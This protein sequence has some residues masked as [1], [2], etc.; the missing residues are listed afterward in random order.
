MFRTSNADFLHELALATTIKRFE[1][2]EVI[3]KKDEIGTSMYYILEGAVDVASD[4]L[5]LIYAKMGPDEYF[6][7]LCLFY[8]IPRTAMIITTQRTIVL[9]LRKSAIAILLARDSELKKS[10]ESIALVNYNRYLNRALQNS[11]SK[12]LLSIS[13]SQSILSNL[14][15]LLE[16]EIV[17]L[18]S[19]FDAE[20][21]SCN[22]FEKGNQVPLT[23]ESFY[24]LVSGELQL[25]SIMNNYAFPVTTAGSFFKLPEASTSTFLATINSPKAEIIT[26]VNVSQITGK[27]KVLAMAECKELNEL[28][29]QQTP[30]R[31]VYISEGLT[32]KM[33][34]SSLKHE[35]DSK[36]MVAKQITPKY[37]AFYDDQQHSNL[38]LRP[39]DT[40]FHVKIVNHK[41]NYR[42]VRC[43]PYPIVTENTSFSHR[44]VQDMEPNE[45]SL[46]FSR[47]NPSELVKM[48]RTCSKMFILLMHPFMWRSLNMR[49]DFRRFEANIST[50]VAFM[51][52]IAL[53]ILDLSNCYAV[54]DTDL[55]IFCMR[56]TGIT[57][58]C[59]SSC[60]KVTDL[61]ISAFQNL[62]LKHLAVPHCSAITGAT[63]GS[64]KKLTSI[65]LSY[66]HRIT[67]VAIET[68]VKKSIG[69]REAIFRR[70]IR[71]SDFSVYLL[72]KFCR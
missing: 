45:L 64:W 26:F 65:D 7:E 41:M 35:T 2:G 8:E 13:V 61:G 49:N 40:H 24:L 60:I 30:T 21:I 55:R 31:K 36:F 37:P 47:L 43:D 23:E 54:T 22:A 6:G 27:A 58:I 9:E 59:L 16:I 50:K 69:I 42:Y 57:S 52:N 66:C 39:V 44:N 20:L 1:I 68:L 63:F 10:I 34:R 32:R 17:E 70:C 29:I 5:K 4:D 28:L 46:I 71:L 48:Q 51:C 67:E 15:A 62:D 56:C 18:V 33:N 12:S 72:L 3:I 53:S 25:N 11:D 19:R 38:V 14:A